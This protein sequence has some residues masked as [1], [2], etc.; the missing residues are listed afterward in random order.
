MTQPVGALHLCG[1]GRYECPFTARPALHGQPWLDLPFMASPG[2]AC[3]S[4]LALARPAIHG[5]PW[6]DLPFTASPVQTCP[7]RPAL[8][9][10]ALHDQT[11]PSRDLSFTASP[12]Q[13]SPSSPALARP[14]LHGQ[15]WLDQPTMASPG[16]ALG[17]GR[18]LRQGSTS[19]HTLAHPTVA[20]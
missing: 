15:L 11:C 10:P 18:L 1:V 12:G 14:A 16:L 4:W 17:G 8:A 13:T 6:P 3:P 7:S 19:T 5:Q 9:R 20:H 2:Q